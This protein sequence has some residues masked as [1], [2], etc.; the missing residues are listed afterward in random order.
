M[1]RPVFKAKVNSVGRGNVF[2][3][4]YDLSNCIAGFRVSADVNNITEVNLRLI[5][6]ELDLDIEGII[7]GE[8]VDDHEDEPQ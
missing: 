4:D 6:V 5:G 2:I 8:Y 3:D 7:K 1:G